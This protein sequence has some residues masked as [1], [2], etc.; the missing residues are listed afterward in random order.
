M[1]G[2]RRLYNTHVLE[3]TAEKM[4]TPLLSTIRDPIESPAQYRASS[5]VKGRLI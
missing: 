3:Y 5:T 2:F 1:N 4:A